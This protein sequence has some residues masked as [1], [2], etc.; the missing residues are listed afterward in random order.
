MNDDIAYKDY[1]KSGD[2]HGAVL[3]PASMIAPVQS[4]FLSELIENEPIFSVFDPFHGSGTALYEAM[5]I[6]PHL[7]L[8][9]CDIN[10]LANLITQVKLQ[11]ISD[12]IHDDIVALKSNITNELTTSEFSFPNMHK[13]LR[14]D[15]IKS[16]AII[17]SSIMAVDD[18]KNRLFFWCIFC[19]TIRRFSNTRSSTYKL[20][21]KEKFTIDSF[22]NKSVEFFLDSINRNFE[23]F[24][25]SS[26]NFIL[27]KKDTLKKIK[28]FDNNTF[29]ISITSPPYGDNAT[30]VPYGQFSMLALY[31]IA[32]CDLEMEGWE[33]DNYS[34]IDSNSMGGK[35]KP[36]SLGEFELSLI[37]IYLEKISVK[38]H[39]KVKLFFD[40]YFH[41]LRELCRVTSKYIILTLGNRT[42]DRIQINL[43]DI[44]MKYLDSLGFFNIKSAE[45]DIPIK[46]TPKVTSRVNKM[47][48]S[49]MNSEYTIVHQKKS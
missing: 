11:G 4:K 17:R 3:Y 46:R 45:R 12:R 40:D 26:S 22:E 31:S 42:V 13:W 9:G 1:K 36:I 38:K 25:L 20:H 33:L 43:T 2:I 6:L 18:E 48:V 16:L 14:N 47:P 28:E 37:N 15:V 41:F 19:D 23:K 39:K 8:V 44:T 10:P 34:K 35:S 49:S 27:Y 32:S 7:H 30:T 24:S 5:R 21:I 29:D